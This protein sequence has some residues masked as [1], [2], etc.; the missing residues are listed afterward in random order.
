MGNAGCPLHPQPR[1]HFVLV[2]S[3]TSKRV[4]RNRPTFPHAMVLRFT[5]CSPGRTGSIATLVSGYVLSKPGW[6]DQNSANLT[7]A[8]RC[9]DHTT[10]PHATPS[11]VR[12]LLTAHKSH[13]PALRSR[14]AQNAAASTA[15]LPAF[16]TM[17]NAPLV[18]WDGKSSKCDLGWLKTEIFLQT[19]LDTPVSKAPDGQIT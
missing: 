10:S 17:A 15:S 7:P 11:L 18:G 14:R 2:R 5:S 6:A 13:R 3:H 16:V 8:S 12:S 9:Q 19:G 1:V 4:H